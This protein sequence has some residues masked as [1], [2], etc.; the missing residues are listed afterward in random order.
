MNSLWK[1]HE[2]RKRFSEVVRAAVASGPQTITHHGRDHVVIMSVS[3]YRRMKGTK[4]SLA[5]FLRESPLAEVELD[6]TRCRGLPRDVDM[7][8]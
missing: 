5:D 1:S 2:A 3:D 8:C 4:Q 6:L 7:P